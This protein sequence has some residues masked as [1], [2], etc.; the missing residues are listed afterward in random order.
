[1]GIAPVR[2]RNDPAQYDDLTDAWWDPFGAFAAL[3]WLAAARAE[4]IPPPPRPGAVLLDVACGA[5]LLAPHLTGR[6]AGWRHTGL[7][8]SQLSLLQA[9]A[10]GVAPVRADAHRLPFATGSLDCVVA[11]EVLE[12]VPDLPAVCAELGRVLAPGGT[13]VVDTISSTRFARVALV[14]VAERL[15]G[16]PPPRIHDPALF[17]SPARLRSLLAPAGI[18]LTQVTGLRPSLRD[19]VGWLTKRSEDVRM[20]HVRS[21]AGVY[22]ALGE[23]E[24]P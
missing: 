13:L 18:R 24:V 4:L 3:R 11:G 22:Q 17:V 6:L 1:M 23:K 21:T 9:R 15:P 7:D 16:G 19:Y 8:L 10:H 14:H 12:H 2:P 5:G 20:L